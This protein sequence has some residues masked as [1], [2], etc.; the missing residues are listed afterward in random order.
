[1]FTNFQPRL[2]ATSRLLFRTSAICYL[3]VSQL[4]DFMDKNLSHVHGFTDDT[5]LY[6]S[7]KA[8]GQVSQ[9]VGVRALGKCIADIQSCNTYETPRSQHLFMLPVLE[10]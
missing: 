6:L 2:L 3:L 9:G 4:F 1:M 8:D 10:I 5:Q 7:F